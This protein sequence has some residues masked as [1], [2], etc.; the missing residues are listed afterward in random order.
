MARRFA[1]PTPPPRAGRCAC[2]R[3]GAHTPCIKRLATLGGACSTCGSF[4]LVWVEAVETID[5]VATLE[6]KQETG[7]ETN[8]YA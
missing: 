8:A 2:A 5:K 3:C 7:S 4:E 6:Q 1:R